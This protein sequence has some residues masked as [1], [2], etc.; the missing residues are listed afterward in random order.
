MYYQKSAED[1]CLQLNV[2]NSGL[3]QE[4]AKKRLE[5]NGPN[6]L[7]EKKSKTIFQMLLAQLKDIMIYILFAAAAISIVLNEV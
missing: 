1:T 7:V 6:S 5:Q 3:S 2:Q 4:E